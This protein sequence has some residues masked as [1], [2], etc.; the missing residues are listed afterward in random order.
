MKEFKRYAGV[1]V[2]N[3]NKVLLCKRSPKESMPGIWS[4][5]SG[6]IEE[7]ETPLDGALREFKEET[8]LTLP[9]KLELVGFI[10]RYKK[11][12]TKKGM[13]YVFYYESDKELTPD[14]TKAKDGHEHTKCG[15]FTKD[16]VPETRDNEQLG[17]IIQK[18]LN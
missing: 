1:L 18:V 9:N 12:K 4:I 10:N 11:D 2:K 16:E 7:G 6:H 14:L 15:Y 17:K 13:V 5:P 3:K 8:D